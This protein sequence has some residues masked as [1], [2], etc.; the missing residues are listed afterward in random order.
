[1]QPE[2][3]DFTTT[4]EISLARQL[5]NPALPMAVARA[6]VAQED[7]LLHFWQ[8][9]FYE[10]AETHWARM[11][12]G[13]M[14]TRLSLATESAMYEGKNAAGDD[15]MKPWA[16]TPGRIKDLETML[17]S[18]V[19]PF[20]G[21]NDVCMALLNG[22][23]D[24]ETRALKDHTP[25]RFNTSVLPFAYDPEAT[26]P[27]WLAFLESSLPGDAEAHAL[28]Q[29][30]FGYV[31]SGKKD[32]HKILAL[33][34]PRRSGKGTVASVLQAMVGPE[35][36]A[37]PI[38]SQLARPFGTEDLIGK[39]LAVMG[40][41]RW[42]GRDTQEAVPILLALG[43]EDGMTI[44]R[45][46]EKS[47]TGRLAVRAMMMSNDLPSFIDPSGALAGR[48][49]LVEFSESFYG[50][51]DR[52]LMNNLLQELPGILNWALDGLAALDDAGAFT[53]PASA[54]GAR[55]EMERGSSPAYDWADSWYDFDAGAERISVEA[56]FT[57]FLDWCKENNIRH[58]SNRRSFS[59]DVRSALK[60]RGVTVKRDTTGQKLTY[61]YGMRRRVAM[62][63]SRDPNDAF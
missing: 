56:A 54:G 26:C 22:V 23:I 32:L 59:R 15:M 63:L 47:W 53:E 16:P 21:E 11:D 14:F 57:D 42:R 6:L 1:M 10:Y 5:P 18:G 51:E 44:N 33:V 31:L 30:W 38:L 29:Q 20:Y 25:A 19:V 58:E 2:E 50:R 48:L 24:V 41:V 7:W 39:R 12:K 27:A 37:A 61:V 4:T 34:G 17:G 35:G 28:I 46:N 45:K 43:S 8:G 9:E 52:R 40:D 13:Q 49:M 62:P 3:P 60:T 55:D 36:W